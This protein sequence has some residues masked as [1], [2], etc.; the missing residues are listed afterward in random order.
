[1]IVL[2][3]GWDWARQNAYNLVPD[4]GDGASYGRGTWSTFWAD[5]ESEIECGVNSSIL[6]AATADV[7]EPVAMNVSGGTNS[8]QACNFNVNSVTI[9]H[10]N[11]LPQPSPLNHVTDVDTSIPDEVEFHKS[12]V[13]GSDAEVIDVTL[14]DLVS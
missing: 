10:N 9:N 14:G 2:G 4:N 11:F 7:H 8:W 3:F 13:V 5:D 1:M 6:I 12:P